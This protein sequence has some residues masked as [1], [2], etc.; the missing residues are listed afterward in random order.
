[1]LVIGGMARGQL[2]VY[3]FGSTASPT[4][5]ATSTA[6][7]LTP[8]AFFGLS[9]TPATGSGTPVYAAGSGGGFFTAAAWTDPA[10]GTNY[11]QFTLTPDE[12][13]SFSA[14]SISFGYRATGTGPTAY[15]LRSSA[16]SFSSDLASATFITD[17]NWHASGS[18]SITLPELATA[19]AFRIY[20]SGASSASGTLRIDD[21]TLGGSVGAIAVPEPATYATV[22]G[23]VAL[24][25]MAIR[26]CRRR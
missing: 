14:T 20:G 8:G 25:G 9:G 19:T 16:D 10:P 4:T 11:F 17:G 13:H 24:A 6:S 26:R 21:V 2:V 12:G 15:A 1:M 5:N 22:F 7:N 23:L 3:S 18:L